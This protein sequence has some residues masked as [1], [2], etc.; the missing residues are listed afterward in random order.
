MSAKIRVKAKAK[1]NTVSMEKPKPQPKQ[2][3]YDPPLPG[4][5][6]IFTDKKVLASQIGYEI[7]PSI[8]DKKAVKWL[9]KNFIATNNDVFVATYPKCGT[10]WLQKIF[11]EIMNYSRSNIKD[12][13]NFKN[14]SY[15]QSGNWRYFPWIEA[16]VSIT[17]RYK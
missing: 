9:Q 13:S 10:T 17:K 16:L 11:V 7:Q 8:L 4:S 12:S 5:F 1:L 6:E 2:D 14:H 15:Y 3:K